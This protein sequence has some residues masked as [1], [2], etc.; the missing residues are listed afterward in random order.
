MYNAKQKQIQFI[1]PPWPK[2]FRKY[3]PPWKFWS[4]P[5]PGHKLCIM[6]NKSK[7]NLLFAH[8]SNKKHNK[9]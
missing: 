6:Q 3:P 9:Y 7:F 1:P 2:N 8:K 5:L 4:F